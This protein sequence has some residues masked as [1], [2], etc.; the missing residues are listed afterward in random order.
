MSNYSLF[1]KAAQAACAEEAEAIRVALK[2]GGDFKEL[3]WTGTEKFCE[4]VDGFS[5]IAKS[6]SVRMGSQVES[7][8]FEGG[9][10]PR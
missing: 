1:L 10:I 8:E 6:V 2:A 4:E 7:V 9:F 3:E 5:Q